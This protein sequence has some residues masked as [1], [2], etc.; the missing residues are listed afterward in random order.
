MSLFDITKNSEEVTRN[1]AKYFNGAKYCEPDTGSKECMGLHYK[2]KYSSKI[3]DTSGSAGYGSMY[4]N[5]RIVLNDGTIIAVEQMDN[6]YRESQCNQYNA[7]GTLK[8]DEDGNIISETCSSTYIAIIRLDVNGNK[9]PN[10][11]GRDAF[12]LLIYKNKIEPGGASFYGLASLKSIL[13]GGS[14]IY[15]NYAIGEPFEW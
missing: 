8:K 7:D 13:S 10:Q 15:T 6:D 3:E 2:I 1:Y 12:Q 5:P 4:N 11:F 9:L 14:A